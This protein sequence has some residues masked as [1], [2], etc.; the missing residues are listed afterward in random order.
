[1]RLGI[2]RLSALTLGGLSALASLAP[3]SA[4]AA[5]AN[6]K[7]DGVHSA[8]LFRCH[9]F[10]AGYVYGRFNAVAGKFVFDA[11]KPEA[12]SVSVTIEAASVDTNEKKRDDHLRSPDFLDVA[13]FPQITFASTAVKKTGENQFEVAGNLTLHGTTKPVTVAMTKTGENM[14]TYKMYRMGFEGTLTINRSEYG[15]SGLPG[16]VGEEVR[17]TIAVEG[18]RE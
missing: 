5:A 12:S 1:M 3:P 11:D 14:D 2:L 17:L 10:K 18:V 7:I 15:V 16:G 4:H 13:K 8:V 9:H 6:Y